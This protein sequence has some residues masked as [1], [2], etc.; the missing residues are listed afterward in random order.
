MALI[1]ITGF[2]CCGKSR[3]ADKLKE[4]LTAKLQ[5]PDYGGPIGSVEIISDDTLGLQ[6]SVYDGVHICSHDNAPSVLKICLESSSEK[7][8][9]GALFTAVHRVLAPNKIVILDSLNYIKGF[10]YQLY[11]AARE[12]KVR[13][14]TVWL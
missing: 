9:R 3:C 10:R 1:T 14:S 6:R 12:S 13:V 11:C 5:D 4:Y 8:A 2:P 7:P